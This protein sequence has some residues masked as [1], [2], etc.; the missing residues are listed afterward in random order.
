MSYRVT[1]L[2]IEIG[3]RMALG[4]EPRTV[5]RIMFAECGVLLASGIAIGVVLAAVTLRYAAALLYG[6]TPLDATSFPLAICGRGLASVFATGVPAGRTS[7]LPPTMP[8]L[9]QVSCT[10]PF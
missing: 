6:L 8:C 3:V 9:A 2:R 4:A 1:R 10:D 7:R 5:I